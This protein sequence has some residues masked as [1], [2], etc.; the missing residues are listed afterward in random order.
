[1]N[2]LDIFFIWNPRI[3]SKIVKIISH[4]Q[5][6]RFVTLGLCEFGLSSSAKGDSG[7]KADRSELF[8][9]NSRFSRGRTNKTQF[10]AIKGKK[11]GDSRV[12]ACGSCVSQSVRHEDWIDSG[13]RMKM[14]RPLEIIWVTSRQIVIGRSNERLQSMGH[15]PLMGDLCLLTLSI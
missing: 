2:L 6:W 9:V 4:K 5:T 10:W 15:G 1:M 12:C 7:V 13:I 8:G 3:A 14:P 11:V